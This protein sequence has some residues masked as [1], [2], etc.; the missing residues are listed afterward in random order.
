[1]TAP[2]AIWW[3]KLVPPTGFEPA[4]SPY[5]GGALSAEL[6]GLKLHGSVV[7]PPDGAS[8]QAVPYW[9]RSSLFIPSTSLHPHEASQPFH[10]ILNDTAEYK[11]SGIDARIAS[12]GSLWPLA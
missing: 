5:E 2:V 9:H 3:F 11:S 6:R 10:W 4:S 1:M 7:E 12:L 8:R